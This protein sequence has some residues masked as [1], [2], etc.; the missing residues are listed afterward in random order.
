MSTCPL[1]RI[2]K[3]KKDQKEINFTHFVLTLRVPH[4]ISSLS[5]FYLPQTFSSSSLSFSNFFS[6]FPWITHTQRHG[7]HQIF[8]FIS[9][10]LTHTEHH[11]SHFTYVLTFFTK[12]YLCVSDSNIQIC[13]LF[14]IFYDSSS[15]TAKNASVEPSFFWSKWFKWKGQ[16]QARL[17]NNRSFEQDLMFLVVE[18]PRYVKYLFLLNFRLFSSFSMKKKNHLFGS[19]LLDLE[20]WSRFCL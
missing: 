20:F 2:L 8:I 12:L 6:F 16:R 18:W 14:I 1:L 15:V 3:I 11:L 9:L 7:E 4:T 5:N 10:F 19:F 13:E 17:S